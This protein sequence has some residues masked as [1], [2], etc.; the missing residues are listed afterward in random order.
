MTERFPRPAV[1]LLTLLGLLLV[2]HQYLTMAKFKVLKSAGYSHFSLFWQ[3]VQEHVGLQSVDWALALLLALLAAVIVGAEARFRHLTFFLDYIARSDRRMC[4]TLVLLSGVAVRYYFAPGMY[5]GGDASAHLAYAHLASRSIAAGEWPLWTNFFGSGTPYLQFYGFLFFVLVAV[6]DWLCRDFYLAV[7]LALAGCHIASGLGMYFFVRLLCR[8]RRAGFVAALAY[9]LSFWH[10]QQVL[11]MGRYPLALFYALLPWVFCGVECALRPSRTVGQMLWAGIALGLLAWT[12]PGYAFWATF[13]VAFYSLLRLG[14]LTGERRAALGAVAVLLGTG[15]VVGAVQTLPMF[16]ERGYTVLGE[17]VVMTGVPDPN[18]RHLLYWSNHMLRAVSLPVE[19]A[20]WYGGYV[21]VS[22]L[23]L[24]SIAAALVVRRRRW[25]GKLPVL[26]CCLALAL[27]LVFAYRWSLLQALP[28]VRAMNAARYL[29]FLV[30]FLAALAGAASHMLTAVL[31][32]RYR[33]ATL[34]V[35]FIC[36]DLL[37]TTFLD[38]YTTPVDAPDKMLDELAV[39]AAAYGDY[40]PPGRLMVTVGGMHPYLAFSWSYFKTGMPLAQADP[41]KLLAAANLFANPFA[42]FLARALGRTGDGDVV[43][44]VKKSQVIPAGIKLLNVRHVL[45]AQEDGN[46]RWFTWGGQSP[47][48]VAPEVAALPG[49]QLVQQALSEERV[50]RLLWAPTELS[51]MQVLEQAYPVVG[52]IRGMG[53]DTRYNTSARFF[54]ADYAG[55]GNLGTTPAVEVIEHRVLNQRV[56]IEL[57]LSERAYARLAYAWYPHLRVEVDGRQVQALRTAGGF[58]CLLLDAG[59]HQIVLQPEW[60]PLRRMLWAL[61]ALV[62]VAAI[63]MSWRERKRR[64]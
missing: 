9:V 43:D 15:I 1:F 51:R 30:F 39:E 23:V 41:G 13:F 26:L 33:L 16:L 58:I 5:W 53:V 36:I 61:S 22:L 32:R 62:W 20:H 14:Q 27:L 50:E 25:R 52:L 19:Y 47:V 17:G 28:P 35:L 59:E 45:V 37:P 12:H 42:Q 21:G 24:A 3:D 44:E 8:S 46:T 54:L 57:R 18:W 56:E 2:L 64:K 29:L 40:A 34:A 10:V 6:F 38:L 49:D 60:S 55:Q 7:K 48:L 11:V 63:G 4:I 31:A